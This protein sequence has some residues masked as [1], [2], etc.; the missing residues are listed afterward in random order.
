MLWNGLA[1]ALSAFLLFLVQPLMARQILPWFGGSAAVWSTC[2]VFFQLTLLAGYFYADVLVRRAKPT[3]QAAIHT[4]LLLAALAVLPLTPPEWLK[5]TG[6][7]APTTRIL[8]VLAL[9]VGLPYLALSTT[10]PL[11]Q[12]W[13][14]R[15]FGGSRVYRLYALSNLFSL[16]ALLAY[17]LLFEP[18]LAN[19]QQAWLWSGL[20][21]VFAAVVIGVAWG[22]ARLRETAPAADPA[23]P[24]TD[25]EETPPPSWLQQGVWLTLA[26]LGSALLLGLSTHLT[27]NIASVP[28]LWV[29]PLGLYLLSFVLCFDGKGWYWRSFYPVAAALLAVAMI[30][31]LSY[32]LKTGHFGLE[33]GVLHLRTAGPLYAVGLLVACMFLHG[34]LVE[35]KPAP[36]HLT[37][38]YLCVSLG[39]AVGG[40]AVGLV[41]PLI[42]DAYWE[43][44]LGLLG[45][46]ALVAALSP[47]PWQRVLGAV[48][49][50]ACL[51][52]GIDD[53]IYVHS[54]VAEMTRNFYG[55]L[56]VKYAGPLGNERG[57]VRLVHGNILHGEQRNDGDDK[58]K[59]TTY[60]GE[61]SGVG[62][63][64]LRLR[65]QNPGQ[66]QRIGLIGL[67]VGTLSAYGR[68]GDHYRLYELNPA[69]LDLA[70]RQ[71]TYLQQCPADPQVVLGDA[72]LSLEHEAPQQ[73]DVLA[74]DAFS[75]DSIPVHLLTAEALTVYRRHLR[76]G[77]VI[78]FHVSNRYLDLPPVVR[79]LADGAGLKA[80][81]VRDDPNKD[82]HLS[83]SDWVLVTD[84]AKLLADLREDELGAEPPAQTGLLA[85]RDDRH[86]LIGVLK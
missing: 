1:I 43:V 84:N 85:W 77:G 36:A 67:G 24:Q 14:A 47:R 13:F 41:A 61:S 59:P 76:P 80:W 58:F 44:P 8:A 17:P 10:G 40:V 62:L 63:A 19:R 34:E 2:L 71:F 74:V 38:F 29:L 7:D 3:T 70:Q 42:F 5:P 9:S 79:G 73:F 28:F 86:D 78:A 20:F 48:A 49:A 53:A 54:D 65:D 75:S 22:N 50:M 31:G 46:A 6:A 23:E 45:V 39:G 60:Y 51:G 33:H 37:R 11:V 32:K 25:Q 18:L 64:I 57:L 56:R 72:R 68:K 66:P 4:G 55:Q 27:Q 52:L 26:A 69:V 21:A 30:L 16:S 15:R 83:R 81:Q 12:A 82:T 35:R